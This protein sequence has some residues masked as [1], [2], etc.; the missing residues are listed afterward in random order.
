MKTQKSFISII[1]TPVLLLG[2][3]PISAVTASAVDTC[4][5]TYDMQGVGEQIA[6]Q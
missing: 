6:P 2:L 3:V 5:V 1:L 4:T